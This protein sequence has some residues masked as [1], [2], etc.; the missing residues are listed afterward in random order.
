MAR[1]IT[2]IEPLP[3]SG[4]GPFKSAEGTSSGGGEKV[5]GGKRSGKKTVIKSKKVADVIEVESE[6]EAGN[7]NDVEEGG[8][9]SGGGGKGKGKAMAK[10]KAKAKATVGVKGKEKGK[11]KEKAEDRDDETDG[12][13]KDEMEGDGDKGGREFG[14]EDED[15][16]DEGDDE[17]DEGMID[18]R[19]EET[20]GGVSVEDGEAQRAIISLNKIDFRDP[21]AVL[22]FGHWNDRPVIEK[23]VKQLLAMI[24][25]QGV[26]AF[27]PANRLPVIAYPVDVSEV[28][29]TTNTNLGSDVPNLE[30]SATGKAKGRI[31]VAGGRH[32]YHAWKLGYEQG[33]KL[34]DKH[35][36]QLATWREKPVKGE[37]AK[38]T[39]ENNVAR[40]KEEI[41]AEE[42]FLDAISVW[43]IVVYDACEWNN[44]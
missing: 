5:E 39:R 38:A 12:L 17:D 41:R 31:E 10:G 32:R 7:A 11:E 4:D 18:D 30:L 15:E 3:R 2:A 36:G 27:N 13:A 9:A 25:K 33:R 42:K 20:G 16:G 37:K 24:R 21:P 28:C 22:H 8:G 14:E 26:R 44:Y 34:I 1:R 23:H 29:I 19:A 35:E 6:D 43:G 40:L